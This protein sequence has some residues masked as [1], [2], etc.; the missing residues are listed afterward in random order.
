MLAVFSG[1][2]LVL[3][4]YNIDARF[5][6]TMQARRV[7]TIKAQVAQIRTRTAQV[8][9]RLRRAKETGPAAWSTGR[10]R[11]RAREGCNRH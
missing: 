5:P 9:A 2:T 11:R 4:K 6:S 7:T 3:L 1:C 10:G 8:E